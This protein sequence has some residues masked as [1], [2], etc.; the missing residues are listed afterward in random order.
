MKL[1]SNGCVIVYNGEIY[2]YIDLKRELLECGHVFVTG[3]DTEVILLVYQAWGLMGLKRL[4]GIFSFSLWDP[5]KNMMILM[6]DRLGVKPLYYGESDHGLAFGSEIKTVLDAVGVNQEIDSQAFSEYLWYGNS[7]EDRT[8]YKGIRSLKPGHWMIVEGEKIKTEPW[9][10]I[11]SWLNSKFDYND[12]NDASDRLRSI[13]D[14]SV[15]RQLVADVPVG[16]FL[17]GGVDSSAIAAA[18]TQ[19]TQHPLLSYTAG[20]DFDKGINELHQARSIASTYGLD[21]H[22][23]HI[24][25]SDV[26]NVLMK[27]S[28]A[29]DEPFADAANI[30]LYMMCEELKGKIKVILQGDGGD[31]LFAGYRRYP[32]LNHVAIWRLWP[33]ALTPI[34]QNFG[35]VG[36]RL[37]RLLTANG[38]ND[39]AMRMAL[40][41]T[42]DTLN[43]S[44]FSLLTDEYKA[45]LSEST[46]PFL[47]YKKSAERFSTFSAVNQ[48]L[49]TDLTVQLPSQFLTKVDRSTMAAGIE[50]RVPLLDENVVKFAVSLPSK[51]KTSRTQRKIILR[52]SQRNRLPSSLLDG[53]KKG[54][55]VPYAHWL[56]TSL[57]D[58]SKEIMLDIANTNLHMF[59]SQKIEKMMLNLKQ[60][61]TTN[62]FMLWKLLQ[63][64]LWYNK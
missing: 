42:M 57:F 30:P 20:F 3:S 7:Y 33:Q 23:L 14:R 64:S 8:F 22:E 55:S 59:S 39:S 47:V 26:S 25:G 46:D 61:D 45:H 43:S 48:M 9:W 44:T 19:S 54:F 56:Q 27:L 1:K 32:S 2:N 40:L 34:V 13:I 49:L 15:K 53:K 51:W 60:G 6:R 4:E 37:A 10:M 5:L 16:I 52:H 63:F 11:E 18:A 29:H 35:N 38:N 41:L 21:H 12:Y 31:E 50:A 17:S 58:F 24:S 36:R 28:R 62:A